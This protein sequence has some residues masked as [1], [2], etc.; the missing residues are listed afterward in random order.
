[1]SPGCIQ[2]NHDYQNGHGLALSSEGAALA[3]QR[4]VAVKLKD[5]LVIETGQD[6]E[7][8]VKALK[9]AGN[10]AEAHEIAGHAHMD[11]ITSV[12]DPSDAGLKYMLGFIKSRL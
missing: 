6:A 1:M 11:M 9:G 3:R 5:L 2:C 10:S 8:M 7:Q 4:G 12:T